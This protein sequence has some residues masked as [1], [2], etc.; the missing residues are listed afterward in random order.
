MAATQAVAADLTPHRRGL[1]PRAD[2]MGF[3]ADRVT[4][5]GVFL[6]ALRFSIVNIMPPCSILTQSQ[7]FILSFKNT[8]K[9]DTDGLNSLF[10]YVSV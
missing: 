3:V 4:L 2:H 9:K 1:D 7:K 8:L 10:I 5:G 6:R